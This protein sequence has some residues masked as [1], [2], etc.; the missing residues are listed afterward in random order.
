LVRISGSEVSGGRVWVVIVAAGKGERFGGAKQFVSLRGRSL[1][2]W[3]VD[4]ALAV[5]D[6]VVVVVPARALDVQGSLAQLGRADVIVAGGPTRAASV[7]AGL[8]VVAPEAEV[9]VVH[10][11][12]RP[13]ASAALFRSVV[14]AVDA[15]ADAVVPGLALTDTIKQV[16]GDLV[17]ATVARDG[18]VAVQTP[19]AF[20][21]DVLR[22]AHRGGADATDDATLVEACGATV[23]VVAGE[24]GNIKIT[25]PLDLEMAEALAPR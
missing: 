2:A 12:A 23:R 14:D 15:G 3:S 11:G 17:V 5:A 20:R 7:R 8:S 18:L 1:V 13:L 24:P 22:R 16:A 19:Q 25:T 9:V 10:D 21:A 4:A 6:R